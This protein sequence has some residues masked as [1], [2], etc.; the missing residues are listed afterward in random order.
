M[1]NV[2]YMQRTITIFRHIKEFQSRFESLVALRSGKSLTEVCA[3][4]DNII[5]A[6]DSNGLHFLCP[7]NDSLGVGDLILLRDC[8]IEGYYCD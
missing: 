1:R 2:R 5:T 8:S 7:R 6:A 4:M 3:H